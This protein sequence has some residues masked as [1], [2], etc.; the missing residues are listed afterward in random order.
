MRGE[1]GISFTGL[2]LCGAISFVMLVLK[3][4]FMDTWSEYPDCQ[5]H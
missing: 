5:I 3:L 1:S 2:Y 4:G